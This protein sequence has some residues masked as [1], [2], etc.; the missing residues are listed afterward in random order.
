MVSCERYEASSNSLLSMKIRAFEA[1]LPVSGLGE[2]ISPPPPWKCCGKTECTERALDPQHSTVNVQLAVLDAQHVQL[3][4]LWGHLPFL[5]HHSPLSL[6]SPTTIW[7]V[8][9]SAEQ[10]SSNGNKGI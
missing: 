8:K 2:V 10:R 4:D 9:L 1:L 5:S 7:E 3:S 6:Q